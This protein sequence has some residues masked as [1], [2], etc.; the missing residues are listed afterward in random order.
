Q[1]SSQ[2]FANF[3]GTFVNGR[4]SVENM[5]TRPYPFIAADNSFGT[6]RGRLYVVYANNEP[7]GSGNKPDIWCRYSDNQGTNWSAPVRI[8]DDPNPQ[9]NHQWQPA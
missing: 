1:M 2:A 4:H 7:V 8:N 3:V 6:Y 9:D 5:R